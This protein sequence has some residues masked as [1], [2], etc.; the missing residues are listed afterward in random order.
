MKTTLLTLLAGLSVFS[1]TA[2]SPAQFQGTG[3]DGIT[4]SPKFREFLNQSKPAKTAVVP[5]TMA[6]PKCKDEFT[7]RADWTAR[8]ANKPS[9]T[10]AKHLCAGCETKVTTVGTGK[11]AMSTA[12]H[13]CSESENRSASCCKTGS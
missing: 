1:F 11:A 13:S 10:V 2:L 5:K 3:V 4:A 9:V 12:V 7:T 8:G 6:C